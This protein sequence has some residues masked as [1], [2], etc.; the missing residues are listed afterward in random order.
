MD[1]GLF[2]KLGFDDSEQREFAK[3]LKQQLLVQTPL[4]VQQNMVALHYP[5]YSAARLKSL[6]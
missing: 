6:I 2:N 5:M 3:A 1:G 4:Q